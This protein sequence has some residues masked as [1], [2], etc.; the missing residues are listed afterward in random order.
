IS[1]IIITRLIGNEPSP[2]TI[3]CWRS[4]QRR[5]SIPV[6]A[7]IAYL[8]CTMDGIRLWSRNLQSTELTLAAN[9]SM[10]ILSAL[11]I[12]TDLARTMIVNFIRNEITR[13]GFSHGII[14]LSGGIDSALVAFLATE[15]LGAPN[16]L[17]VLMPY[18]TSNPASRADAELVAE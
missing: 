18:R 17:G 4:D 10:N 9:S 5:I 13:V 3:R 7:D 8:P 14:G 15:A 1:T 12:N 16:V 6:C 2:I 11:E